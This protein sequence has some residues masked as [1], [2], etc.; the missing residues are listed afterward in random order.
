LRK[1]LRLTSQQFP[2]TEEGFIDKIELYKLAYGKLELP[3][4]TLDEMTFWEFS[5][6]FMGRLEAEKEEME[7]LAHVVRAGVVSAMNGKEI[8]LF[9][10]NKKQATSDRITKEQREDTL[11]ELEYL[12]EKKE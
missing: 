2:V 3:W 6:I 7:N 8:N 5:S 9:E 10:D 4:G 12:Y 1:L 11:N